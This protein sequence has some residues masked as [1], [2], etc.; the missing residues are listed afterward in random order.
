MNRSEVVEAIESIASRAYSSKGQ[1]LSIEY[2]D[3]VYSIYIV[4]EDRGTFLEV[5][6]DQLVVA[7]AAI[8]SKGLFAGSA[9]NPEI[10]LRLRQ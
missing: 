10:W 5:S 9:S 7:Y 8:D 4:E 6:I 1:A 3:E 2:N